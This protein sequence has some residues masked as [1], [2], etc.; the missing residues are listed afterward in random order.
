MRLNH[1]N[2]CSSDVPALA[3]FFTEHF[4]YS[5]VQAG[6]VP[7]HIHEANA[8]TEFAMLDG[9]DGSSLVLTQIV[10]PGPSSYP[11]NFHFGIAMDSPEDVCAKNAE[12]SDA[13]YCA[14]DV[15]RF[16]A[17]G[18]DWT[19]FTCD[20]GDGLRVEVNHRSVKTSSDKRVQQH[21]T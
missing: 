19:T 13:G 2:L 9:A 18:A 12:L 17:V 7:D 14:D 1:I 21:S 10:P 5:V 8:G 3:S 16:E 6:K 11:T 20:L 4:G 15:K